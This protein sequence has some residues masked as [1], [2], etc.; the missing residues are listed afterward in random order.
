LTPAGSA[1]YKRRLLQRGNTMKFKPL[2]DR[3]LLKP[4]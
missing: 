4:M 3:L 2:H 1:S